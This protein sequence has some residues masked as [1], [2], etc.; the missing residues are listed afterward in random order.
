MATLTFPE[1]LSSLPTDSSIPA[2][3]RLSLL[4]Q[5]AGQTQDQFGQMLTPPR[6]KG[7]VSGWE[8]CTKR[9][10]LDIAAQVEA[11]VGIPARD[12]ANAPSPGQLVDP[13]GSP[14]E[15][16]QSEKVAA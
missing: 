2:G 13:N 3:E 10:P 15:A 7:T 5:A 6:S 11:L 4:R 12:W 16:A 8:G 1:S 9:P 14:T